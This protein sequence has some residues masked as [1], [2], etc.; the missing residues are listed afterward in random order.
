MR[1]LAV[2]NSDASRHMPEVAGEQQTRPRAPCA[3]S[4]MWNSVPT[5]RDGEQDDAGG[6]GGGAAQTVAGPPGQIVADSIARGLAGKA[7]NSPN[8]GTPSVIRC[9]LP[10]S[11]SR[12]TASQA[13]A[14]AEPAVCRQRRSVVESGST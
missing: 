4:A 14:G 1:A 3:T 5:L 7:R 11:A 6:A 10:N 13:S 9:R 12:L 8:R 2:G